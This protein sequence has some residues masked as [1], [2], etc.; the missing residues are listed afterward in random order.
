MKCAFYAISVPA[1]SWAPDRYRL[2]FP[3]EAP[4]SIRAMPVF[5]LGPNFRFDRNSGELVR[6]RRF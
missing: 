2:E 1:K 3:I 4:F 5:Q 6:R